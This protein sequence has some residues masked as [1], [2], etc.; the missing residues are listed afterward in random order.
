MTVCYPCIQTID[1]QHAI[2]DTHWNGCV[3]PS[4]ADDCMLV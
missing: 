3:K 2:D 4:L 1:Q